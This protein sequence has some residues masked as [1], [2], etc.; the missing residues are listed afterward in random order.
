VA[1]SKSSLGGA[2][3]F[4]TLVTTKVMVA[5]K[6]HGEE[7][8]LGLSE[9]KLGPAIDRFVADLVAISRMA[10]NFF[11]LNIGGNRTT[12]QVVAAG[13]YQYAN[14]WINSKNF[15]WRRRQGKNMIELVDMTQ[16]GFPSSYSFSDVLAVLQK[17][18]LNRPVYED[19]LLFGEQ[20][21]EKQRERSIMFPH[22]PGLG[23]GGCPDVVCLWGGDG[24]RELFLGWSGFR[25][26]SI[27]LVA[28]VRK[29]LHF[30]AISGVLVV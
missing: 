7:I 8:V 16:H 28:G 10:S 14:T 29:S 3:G 30:S 9:E 23:A 13:K 1:K 25:W 21:P 22:E 2:L 4:I 5:I 12:E 11:L 26:C 17:L 24:R 27:A 19:G 15:P 6:E 18:G 20:H